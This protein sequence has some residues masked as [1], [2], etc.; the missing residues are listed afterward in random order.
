MVCVNGKEGP[1]VQ[2]VKGDLTTDRVGEAKVGK[3]LLQELDELGADLVL[4]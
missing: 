2:D 1:H 4:L 3:L